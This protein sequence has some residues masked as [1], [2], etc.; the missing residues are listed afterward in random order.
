[1]W[2]TEKI[3]SNT[4]V[5]GDINMPDIDWEVGRSEAKGRTLLETVQEENLQQMVRFPTHTKGNTLDLLITN[6]LERVLTVTNGGQLGRSDHCIVL[7][8]IECSV[9]RKVGMPT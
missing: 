3:D 9:S 1:M 2:N 7:V 8:E 4:V 6:C 5:I